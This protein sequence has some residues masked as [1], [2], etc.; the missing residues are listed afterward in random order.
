MSGT[1]LAHHLAMANRLPTMPGSFSEQE[2]EFFRVGATIGQAEPIETF[3]DLD[4]G[5]EPNPGLWRRMF[6]R[7]SAKR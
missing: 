2:E 3:E 4:A 6:G 7:R 5:R 1:S